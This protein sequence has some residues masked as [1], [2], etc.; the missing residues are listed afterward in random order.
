[1]N[2][3]WL[4]TLEVQNQKPEIETSNGTDQKRGGGGAEIEILH[5]FYDFVFLEFDSLTSPKFN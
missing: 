5:L 1:M 4:V 2:L 3:E